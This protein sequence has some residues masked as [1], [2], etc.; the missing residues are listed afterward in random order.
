M[1][2]KKP[3]QL[4]TSLWNLD[5]LPHSPCGLL[6]CFPVGMAREAGEVY[7]AGAPGLQL[8]LLLVICRFCK[9]PKLGEGFPPPWVVSSGTVMV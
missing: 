6:S 3:A 9:F 5:A 4:S 2:L 7:P 8:R 1:S